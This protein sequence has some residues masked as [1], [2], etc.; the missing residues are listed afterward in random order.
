MPPSLPDVAGLMRPPDFNSESAPG[1]P[2]QPGA[3][4]VANKTMVLILMSFSTTR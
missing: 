4:V 3:M 2:V 1:L